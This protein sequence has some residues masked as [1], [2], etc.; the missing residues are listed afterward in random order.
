MVNKT[1]I[2]AL[3]EAGLSC[4][5]PTRERLRWMARELTE[6]DKHDAYER[7]EAWGPRAVQLMQELRREL[8]RDTADR[9]GQMLMR[10]NR[11]SVDHRYNESEVEDIYE[12]PYGPHTR[13][14]NPVAILSAIRCY[15][16]QSCEHPGWETSEA[17]AYCEA[18]QLAMI[19]R[20]PGYDDAP[21]EI[22]DRSQYAA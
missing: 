7:G 15:E 5:I 14:I 9:T 18:L 8:T 6:E 11:L 3:I 17:K 21:W 16:Y 19:R 20:L 1:H 4:N 22:T 10:E 13:H 2:D 12:Y